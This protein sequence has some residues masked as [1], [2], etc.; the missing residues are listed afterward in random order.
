MQDLVYSA[1]QMNSKALEMFT[2]FGIT[3]EYAA[4]N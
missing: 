1:L 4:F 3:F 2:I